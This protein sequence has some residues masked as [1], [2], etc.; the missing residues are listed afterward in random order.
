MDHL[1]FRLLGSID[2]CVG[3]RRLEL[4]PRKRRYVLAALLL[5]LNRPVAVERLIDAVWEGDP[6]DSA[7]MTVQGHVY[8]LRR[9]LVGAQVETD[10]SGYV[11]RADPEQVDVLRFR[12]LA[13][14]AA[15][16]GDEAGA[17]LLEEALELWLGPALGEPGGGTSLAVAAVELEEA[18]LAAVEELA[19]RRLRLGQ[20]ERAVA[21]LRAIV[22]AAPHHERLVSLLMTA[23]FRVGRQAEALELYERTRRLL[24]DQLGVSPGRELQATFESVLTA[25]V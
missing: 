17:A 11:L 20:P 15:V 13:A 19:R 14:E 24:A 6:P 10:A 1:E 2:A 5:D 21:P 7:R 12:R 18:R 25:R 8:R 23:F 3:G 4:G 16:A 22:T 9:T